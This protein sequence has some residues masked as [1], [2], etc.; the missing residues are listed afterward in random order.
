MADRPQSAHPQNGYMR[1][2][3]VVRS[4]WEMGETIRP[5]AR[6]VLNSASSGRTIVQA[7]ITTRC[8]A[9]GGGRNRC[10]LPS[11]KAPG[12]PP[13]CG[14]CWRVM[15]HQVHVT[16]ALLPPT[17]LC[18][19]S[20]YLQAGGL[21]YS[22]LPPGLPSPVWSAMPQTFRTGGNTYRPKTGARPGVG[23]CLSPAAQGR[24]CGCW[25]MAPKIPT[26]QPRTCACDGR[27]R[28][29]PCTCDQGKVLR[30]GRVLP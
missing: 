10:A 5:S 26:L 1:D 9:G 8:G 29:G 28:K 19:F 18:R 15:P 3:I 21:L 24:S 14:L 23:A 16:G 2:H 12:L 22:L 25:I 6:H 7:L 13:P 17:G 11:V 27:G 4:K 30:C 20:S